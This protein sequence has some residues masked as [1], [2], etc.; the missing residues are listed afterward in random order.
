MQ[1]IIA[2]LLHLLQ[3]QLQ[4]LQL[5]PATGVSD[6]SIGSVQ[7]RKATALQAVGF[8]CIAEVHRSCSCK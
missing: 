2:G 6:I 5:Q 7:G 1:V 8:G 4:V 3:P